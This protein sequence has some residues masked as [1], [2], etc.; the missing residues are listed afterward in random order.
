MELPK[1]TGQSPLLPCFSSVS[2]LLGFGAQ[3]FNYS[4]IGKHLLPVARFA[5]IQLNK[6][7]VSVSQHPGQPSL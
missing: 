5:F 1:L 4:R 6:T 3:P 7:R 2:S